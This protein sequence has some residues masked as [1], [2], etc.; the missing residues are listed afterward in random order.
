M[1]QLEKE[2][3]LL[4]SAKRVPCLWYLNSPLLLPARANDDSPPRCFAGGDHGA[5]TGIFRPRGEVHC[6]CETATTFPFQ[7]AAGEQ[8]PRPSR[9]RDADG[10]EGDLARGPWGADVQCRTAA[11][12]DGVGDDDYFGTRYCRQNDI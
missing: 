8:P 1:L 9:A 2:E 11:P 5:V 3:T 4:A 7:S 10:Q 12:Y 6:H